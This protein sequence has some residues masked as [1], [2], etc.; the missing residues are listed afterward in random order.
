M[1]W[2][3]RSYQPLASLLTILFKVGVDSTCGKIDSQCFSK[4]N[5]PTIAEMLIEIAKLGGYLDRKNDSPPGTLVLWRGWKRL[6]DI[7]EG[8]AMAIEL[9]GI[10]G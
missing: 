2:I 3:N 7:A 5:S 9:G 1:G 4:T 10:C 8:W 6:I